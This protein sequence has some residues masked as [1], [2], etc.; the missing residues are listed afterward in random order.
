MLILK[1]MFKLTDSGV[2][3]SAVFDLRFKYAL[4]C[5]SLPNSPVSA[6]SLAR[7]RTKVSAY[8]RKTGV[9]LLEEE[10]NSL[11]EPLRNMLKRYRIKPAAG[12]RLAAFKP[13]Q[14]KKKKQK[15]K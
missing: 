1:D 13:Q 15:Q 12:S 8:K 6:P 11:Q 3:Q 7:F 2:V 5:S 9:D 10:Y 14:A 4:N